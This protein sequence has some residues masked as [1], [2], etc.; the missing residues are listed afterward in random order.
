[1]ASTDNILGFLL[2]YVAFFGAVAFFSSQVASAGVTA[3]F[4]SSID[5]S[6][7]PSMASAAA[8]VGG[9]NLLTYIVFVADMLVY[10]FGL[11]G[12]TLFGVP[13]AWAALVALP[14]D[15]GLV[16]SVVRLLRG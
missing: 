4:G 11:Q 16:Y 2:F 10:F 1:M 13:A 7:V 12:A 3:G 9:I 14:L 5:V 8:T 6:A 15:A